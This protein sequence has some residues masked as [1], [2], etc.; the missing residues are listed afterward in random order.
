M[1][2]APRATAAKLSHARASVERLVRD[3]PVAGDEPFENPWELRAFAIAVATH[4]NGH[5]EW[6]E[7]QDWLIRSIRD[8]EN[9]NNGQPWSYYAHWL[10]ALESVLASK[11]AI[12]QDSLDERMSV[13]LST[14]RD[15]H[16]QRARRDPV[17]ISPALTS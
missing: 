1:S 11:G 2:S 17:A 7:F 16:H 12:S 6:N 10:A 13:V 14:P 4:Q 5:Y 15:A 9:H 3:L 8:W